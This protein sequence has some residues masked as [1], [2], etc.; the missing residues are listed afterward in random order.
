VKLGNGPPGSSPLDIK[1]IQWDIPK[2]GIC[3]LE[4][5]GGIN[6]GLVTIL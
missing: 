2:D 4:M 6:Y 5:S 1:I 3:L